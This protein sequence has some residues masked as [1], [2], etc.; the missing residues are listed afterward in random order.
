MSDDH[1]G[2]LTRR[3][4]ILPHTTEPKILMWP[5]GGSWTLPCVVSHG[6]GRWRDAETVNSKVQEELGDHV[7]ALRCLSNVDDHAAR[8]SHIVYVLENRG[9]SNGIMSKG[10]WIETETLSALTL[11]Y[12]EHRNFILGVLEEMKGRHVPYRRPPWA[13]PEWFE[14]AAG[15]FSE[16]L[17]GLGYNQ[18]S[19]IEWI[20]NCPLASILRAHTTT[21]KLYLKACTTLP[22]FADEPLLTSRLAVL[23]PERVPRPLAIHQKESWMLLPD[24]GDPRRGATTQERGEIVDLFARLQIQSIQHV[25]ELLRSGCPDLRPDKLEDHVNLLHNVDGTTYGVSETQLERFRATLHRVKELWEQLASYG[26]PCTLANG[27][28]HLGNVAFYEGRHVFFDWGQGC[29]THPFIDMGI[30]F[31]EAELD[32]EFLERYLS[33]WTSYESMGRLQEAW[34]LAMPLSQI[35]FTIIYHHAVQH[36]GPEPEEMRV[37]DFEPIPSPR[38]LVSP[39]AQDT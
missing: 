18:V 10:K 31:Q 30:F 35:H 38:S 23:F 32:P 12:P 34:A 25:E 19:P 27:D 24:L 21:G 36:L 14:L 9:S 6:H 26:I 20:Y 2:W 17:E 37:G 8:V 39:Q 7:R 1:E 4:V 13:L 16:Q 22:L 3:F 29:V 15:W 33:F 11:S 28:M 5:D